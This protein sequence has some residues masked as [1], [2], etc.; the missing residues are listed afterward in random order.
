MLFLLVCK[1][2]SILIHYTRKSR[3]CTCMSVKFT[4]GLILPQILPHS[5]RG[6]SYILWSRMLFKVISSPI[7][8]ELTRQRIHSSSCYWETRKCKLLCPEDILYYLFNHPGFSLL[9]LYSFVYVYLHL[10]VLFLIYFKDCVTERHSLKKK[11]VAGWEQS[12]RQNLWHCQVIFIYFLWF[13][14]FCICNV[15]I[16]LNIL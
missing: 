3:D 9:I 2:W 1:Y 8:F 5:V 12:S 6:F 10:Y 14:W 11:Y 7:F 16:L 13:D 4:S 15:H